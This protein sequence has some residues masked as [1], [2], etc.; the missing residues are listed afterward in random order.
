VPLG[1]LFGTVIGA[2]I[3]SPRWRPL[4]MTSSGGAAGLP[5]SVGL[6]MQLHF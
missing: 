1:A 6:G 2:V 5:T 3:S 4:V